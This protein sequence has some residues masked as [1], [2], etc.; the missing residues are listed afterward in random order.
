MQTLTRNRVF[1]LFCSMYKLKES[2][3]TEY[4][5]FKHYFLVRDMKPPFTKK[6]N[7]PLP[8]CCLI[9]YSYL[10]NWPSA[11]SKLRTEE[12]FL[13]WIFLWNSCIQSKSTQGKSQTSTLARDIKQTPSIENSGVERVFL[14]S[15]QRYRNPVFKE[16]EAYEH[17]CQEQRWTGRQ[18]DNER[19]FTIYSL[20]MGI[21]K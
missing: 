12:N 4:L 18:L 19:L 3:C 17:C 5:F 14:F 9:N 15:T 6:G 2:K 8:S 7:D 13:L 10:S 11:T 20:L 16:R 1:C 21:P